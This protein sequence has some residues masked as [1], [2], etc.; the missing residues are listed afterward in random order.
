MLL[1]ISF[2]AYPYE[3]TTHLH[4]CRHLQARAIEVWLPALV[5]IMLALMALIR[6][7]MNPETP[8]K[9]KVSTFA[10]LFYVAL[11]LITVLAITLPPESTPYSIR[12]IPLYFANTCLSFFVCCIFAKVSTHYLDLVIKCINAGIVIQVMNEHDKAAIALLL[13]L[14]CIFTIYWVIQL[15]FIS[16]KLDDQVTWSWAVV[17]IPTYTVDVGLLCMGCTTSIA[18]SLTADAPNFAIVGTNLSYWC[19]IIPIFI[20]EV[21]LGC[22]EYTSFSAVIVSLP[23]FVGYGTAIAYYGLL[24]FLDT[25]DVSLRICSTHDNDKLRCHEPVVI[26]LLSSNQLLS[27]V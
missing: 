16:L 10:A 8:E 14:S 11:N 20:S 25:V 23:I 2:N 19:F 27:T 21:L 3:L 22:K 12:L 9:L 7:I 13:F 6:V 24:K 18:L 4:T 26:P 15:A 1:V 5:W 17:L